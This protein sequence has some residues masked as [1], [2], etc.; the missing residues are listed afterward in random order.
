MRRRPLSV[1]AEAAIGEAI[2]ERRW[3]TCS[4]AVLVVILG[5]TLAGCGLTGG[6]PTAP[7]GGLL[8]LSSQRET[9]TLRKQVEQDPFPSAGEVL[10]KPAGTAGLTVR[11][12]SLP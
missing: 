11:T 1:A 4:S 7:A 2:A 8:D 9:E 10:A 5:A 3:P 6:I 12:G